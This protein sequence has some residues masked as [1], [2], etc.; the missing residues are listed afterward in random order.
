MTAVPYLDQ[1]AAA[2]HMALEMPKG[3]QRDRIRSMRGLIQEFNVFRWAG[4]M[5]LMLPA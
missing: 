3:E 5:L 2:L 4:R 1:C